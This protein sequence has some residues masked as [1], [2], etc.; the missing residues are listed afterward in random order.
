MLSWGS[1][2]SVP[3]MPSISL[4]ISFLS[5]F[6]CLANGRVDGRSDKSSHQINTGIV[7]NKQLMKKCASISIILPAYQNKFFQT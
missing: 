6:L 4:L 1:F 3:S 2:L 7:D 5:F